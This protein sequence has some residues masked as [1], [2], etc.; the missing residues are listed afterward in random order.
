MTERIYCDI[1]QDYGYV[2]SNG[3]TME[4]IATCKCPKFLLLGENE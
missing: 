1:C 3:S 2:Y 4:V